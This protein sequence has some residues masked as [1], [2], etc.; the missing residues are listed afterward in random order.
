L[1]AFSTEES[2][3]STI[4]SNDYH[5]V[6]QV[7][8]D[9]GYAAQVIRLP[10]NIGKE[11]WNSLV[12]TI[13]AKC[14]CT[15]WAGSTNLD[16]AIGFRFR[17]YDR[18]FVVG[19]ATVFTGEGKFLGSLNQSISQPRLRGM[20]L[21]EEFIDDML[22]GILNLVGTLR[23][24]KVLV[25]RLGQA[26][27]EEVQGF[28]SFFDA[29][30][31]IFSFCTLSS[32]FIRA[33]LLSNVRIRNRDTRM[34]SA[35]TYLQIAEKTALY[36]P[37]GRFQQYV[38]PLLSIP[39]G[40]LVEA[41]AGTLYPVLGDLLREIHTLAYLNPNCVQG[42]PRSL[43]VT[44]GFALMIGKFLLN[45]IQVTRPRLKLIPWFL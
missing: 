24:K 37:T 3:Q 6:K 4:F 40:F 31:A 41:R 18:G 9:N 43:P 16:Y 39:R 27:G 14:G 32:S 45:N 19:V 25:T 30:G 34:V 26:S 20:K 42:T 17:K 44:L 8:T 13:A 28:A 35:G 1:V 22:R 21:S 7:A 36:F 23:G 29:Q 12:A 2:P 33:E 38:P 10:R 5:C 15:L 11:I